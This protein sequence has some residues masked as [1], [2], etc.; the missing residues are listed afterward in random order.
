[1]KKSHLI[2][3]LF[4]YL[5]TLLCSCESK[6]YSVEVSD[7]IVNVKMHS[8]S[9]GIVGI[10]QVGYDGFTYE[11]VEKKVFDKIRSR[12]YDGNYS[13]VVTL[14]FLDSYGNYYDGTPVKVTSLNASEVKRYASYSY[15]RGST[16]ISDA[17]PWN[18]KY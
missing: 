13:I 9:M 16:H 15:F 5:I 3:S 12:S 8:P 10:N 2:F 1:M 6:N 17:F 14:Q 4:C 11:E 7:G 18:H